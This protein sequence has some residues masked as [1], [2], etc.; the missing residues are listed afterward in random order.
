M[1]T[2]LP[3]K[4]VVV[5]LHPNLIRT[6]QVLSWVKSSAEEHLK[7]TSA[8][9]VKASALSASETLTLT[10]LPGNLVRHNAPYAKAFEPP[11]LTS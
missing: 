6:K 3:L 4:G 1:G 5:E 8:S 10:G 2:V 11:D 9:T 7:V